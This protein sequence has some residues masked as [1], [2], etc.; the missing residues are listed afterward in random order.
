MQHKK[1]NFKIDITHV[2]VLKTNYIFPIEM[3]ADVCPLPGTGQNLPLPLLLPLRFRSR[4]I[5]SMVVNAP[6]GKV[7]KSLPVVR[8][9]TNKLL[10]SVDAVVGL[11]HLVTTVADKPMATVLP[12]LVLVRCLQRL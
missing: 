8:L 10:V 1:K 11:E 9:A 4:M 3:V 7:A 12:N 6:H 2:L 5:S